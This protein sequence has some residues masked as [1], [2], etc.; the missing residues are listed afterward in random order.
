[1]L[2][3]LFLL[4]ANAGVPPP[5]AHPIEYCPAT[6]IVRAE[7]VT[8]S[9]EDQL[10]AARRYGFELRGEGA[11]EVSNATLAFDTDA[12]WFTVDVP[13][14]T[15][16]VKL[17]HFAKPYDDYVDREFVSKP[18]YVAFART[19]H[20][21]RVWVLSAQAHGPGA[22]DWND[23]G[24]V[25]CEPDAE[26]DMHDYSMEGPAV[27][28]D[29]LGIVPP[30]AAML[31]PSPAAAQRTIAC[32]KPFDD[33]HTLDDFSPDAVRGNGHYNA[34]AT[35]IRVA[36]NADGSV[37]GSWVVSSSGYADADEAA[38]AA[39]YRTGFSPGRAYCRN[40]PAVF[41]VSMHYRTYAIQY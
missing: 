9:N 15:L 16:S 14:V 10:R 5:P 34:K 25:A 35:L 27:D 2:P 39:P 18:M 40:V 33:F 26:R 28:A 11:R 13:A 22:F 19:V 41:S 31:T 8:R 23:R 38:R 30:D 17:R 1:M 32:R 21:N 29:P 7:G 12:G 4:L 24:V 3:A 6:A 20:V 37:A 36:L